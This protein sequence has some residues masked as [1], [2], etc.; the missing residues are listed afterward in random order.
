[1]DRFK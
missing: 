1:M